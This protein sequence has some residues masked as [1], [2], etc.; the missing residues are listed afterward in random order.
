MGQPDNNIEIGQNDMTDR[1][2]AYVVSR[3]YSISY[4]VY[5]IRGIL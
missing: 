2:F 1:K 3:L 4:T 5:V